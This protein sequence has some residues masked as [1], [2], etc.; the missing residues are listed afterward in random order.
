MIAAMP[1]LRRNLLLVLAALAS[2]IVMSEVDR[3]IADT[4]VE[5]ESFSLSEVLGP[6][7]AIHTD[8]WTTWVSA[9]TAF[10]VFVSVYLVFGLV[11]LAIYALAGFRVFSS[12]PVAVALL[13]AHVALQLFESAFVVNAL[14]AASAQGALFTGLVVVSTAKWATLLAA[15]VAALRSRA[16]RD[17]YRP[18][19]RR[20]RK[21]AYTHRIALVVVIAIAA[22]STLPR[23]GIFEQLPDVQRSWL[24]S[25]SGAVHMATAFGAIAILTLTLFVLGRRRSE[26]TYRTFVA[27]E[28]TTSESSIWW[29]LSGPMAAV[30]VIGIFAAT[31]NERFIDLPTFGLFFF[32]LIGLLVASFAI[33]LLAELW[34]VELWMP[35]LPPVSFTR[36]L[37]DRLAGD[38]IA[39]LLVPVAGLGL[40]RSFVAPFVLS[41]GDMGTGDAAFS[42]ALF[43]YLGLCV[44][45]IAL[46]FGAP[47]LLDAIASRI[48]LAAV[49][50]FTNSGSTV[51]TRAVLP[52][53]YSPTP[54]ATRLWAVAPIFVAGAGFLLWITLEPRAV[55]GFLG[56]AATTTLAFGAWA[57]VIGVGIS[58]MQSTKPL[59]VFRLLHLRSNPVLALLVIVP[60]IVAQFG[61]SAPLHA[62]QKTDSDIAESDRLSLAQAFDEW[63]DDS[64]ACRSFVAEDDATVAYRPMVL[65]AAEG[66]GIRASTWTVDVLSQLATAGPCARNAVLLS[67]GASGGSVGLTMFRR[68]G[69]PGAAVDRVTALGDGDALAAVIAGTFVGDIVAGTAGIRVP[70]ARVV[71]PGE[72]AVIEWQDRAG[73]MQGVWREKVSAL[74]KPFNLENQS[75]TGWLVLN[76]TTINP[77]CK[78]LV[79]QLD[80]GLPSTVAIDT[81]PSR[82][83][84]DCRNGTAELPGSLDLIEAYG[85]CPTN[86]DWATA[87]ML[88]ARFPF[89]TPAGRLS[90]STAGP[91]ELC[92]TVP[93]L[94]LIDGGYYD[95]SALGTISDLAPEL[96]SI[97][98]AHNATAIAK[99]ED[100]V[101]P[102]VAYVRNSAGADVEAPAPAITQELLVPSTGFGT[103]DLQLE[104][105][106]WLQRISNTLASVCPSDPIGETSADDLLAQ[107]QCQDALG[108]VRDDLGFGVAVIAPNTAPSLEAPLGWQLSNASRELLCAKLV[109]QWEAVDGP[110]RPYGALPELVALLEP[111]AQAPTAETAVCAR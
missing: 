90:P 32:I 54:T 23:S 2:I 21:A 42:P 19:L 1:A 99:G 33:R 55:S 110:A 109:A 88:S 105:G 92:A 28:P 15:L 95:N 59:A 35:E 16:V 6:L 18:K 24:D 71:E 69:N 9:S 10:S 49:S 104:P 108:A 94:Q 74:Y 47:P 103:K 96:A 72:A 30:L 20:I 43:V 34:G 83:S 13:A 106:T 97:V 51:F 25:T 27:S 14:F 58:E 50:T 65:A 52:F 75:P 111:S 61:G 85:E 31:G 17:A 5:G 36:Y 8:A 98:A 45:G 76:S 12:S 62:L 4:L 7:A 56:A 11:L 79:S 84:P 39:G 86:L 82:R 93:D 44:V 70:T 87:A 66:G 60:V 53:D 67:S 37:D 22:F 29:W 100:L 26:R 78:V 48:D 40:V 80:L 38:V 63:Y 68:A 64:G 77:N 46:V 101:I 41:L 73:L 102:V 89:V 91:G 3:L 57:A 107:S 81:K